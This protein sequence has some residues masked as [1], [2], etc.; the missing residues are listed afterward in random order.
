M[1]DGSVFVQTNNMIFKN[2]A[3]LCDLFGCIYS[4]FDPI[5]LAHFNFF[6]TLIISTRAHFYSVINKRSEIKQDVAEDF[7][8]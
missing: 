5:C 2:S 7:Q 4:S 1:Q 3:F 8:T 6:P